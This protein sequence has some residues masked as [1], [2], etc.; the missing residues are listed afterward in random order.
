NSIKGELSAD[1]QEEFLKSKSNYSAKELAEVVRFLKKQ[2]PQKAGFKDCIDVCGKGGTC[3]KR[4]NTST[5]SAFVLASLGVKVAKHGNKAS[6]GRFGS[7]DLLESLGVKF[8]NNISDIEKI[9]SLENLAFFF[10]PYF[11]PVMKI[12]AEARK[13]IGKP[14]FFNILGPLLNPA[15]AKRQIIGTTFKDKMGIIAETCRLLG[16]EK[17]YVVCGEDSLDEVTLTGKT[18]ITELNNGKIKNYTISPGDFGV[19]KSTFE[20]IQGGDAETNTKIA[21]E[22]LE[23]KCKTRHLDLVLINTALGLKL[24]D[25]VK[26]LKEGYKMALAA[27]KQGI[28]YEKYQ[29]YKTI[30]GMSGLLLEIV[31]NKK[32]E[33][34]KRKHN[35]GKIKNS[36]RDFTKAISG[37]NLALIAEIKKHSPSLGKICGKEFDPVEI[38]KNYE[39]SGA[40]AISV[41]CDKKYFHGDLKYLQ[42]VSKNTDKIP[43]LCKDFIIDEYQIYEARKYGADAILLIAAI[44]TEKQL[45]T[46]M[47]I[48][49]SLEMAALCEVH[50][51]EELTK[52][53]KAQTEIIGINNRNLNTLTVDLSTTQEL[54]KHIP[55][56][57][58][59]V[60]ESGIHSKKD[61]EALPENVSA[62]LVGTS[63]MKGAKITDFIK[64]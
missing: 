27:V 51:L 31:E 12:F 15:S 22:I 63:L 24:V 61:V 38:A 16:Q 8:S 55:K 33:V 7:F 44:L 42:K 53:L 59:I 3:L 48:A 37:K 25:K 47:E 45:T 14:T 34:G 41:L 50:T 36:T 46:F 4:I 43:L 30:S 57:K 54:A 20:E 2:M 39:T 28:C 56:N 58:I 23:G 17:V 6:S 40:S 62:I 11:H 5:V 29:Q 19:G 49:K 1:R 26:T 18:F 32:R 64:N 9:Y 13:R 21:F 35:L 52:G 10:A 60:S